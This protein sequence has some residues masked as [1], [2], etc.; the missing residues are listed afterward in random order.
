VSDSQI[1]ASTQL[2]H[3][4]KDSVKQNPDGGFSGLSDSHADDA[5]VSAQLRLE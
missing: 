5:I 1:T 2:K 3:S 4:T